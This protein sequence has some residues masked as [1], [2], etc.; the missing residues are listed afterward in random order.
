[1]KLAVDLGEADP[2]P[3]VRL[4][5]HLRKE[6]LNGTLTPPSRL[7]SRRRWYYWSAW[8]NPGGVPGR[9]PA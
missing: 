4:A 3:Y 6:I 2:R 5:A 8:P 7:L 1:V 9:R